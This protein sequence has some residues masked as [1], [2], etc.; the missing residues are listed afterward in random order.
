MLVEKL[1]SLVYLF[2]ILFTIRFTLIKIKF[3]IKIQKFVII[4]ISPIISENV[5]VVHSHQ[6][7]DLQILSHC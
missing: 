3:S 4:H 7:Q 5:F 2:L 1:P 6:Q